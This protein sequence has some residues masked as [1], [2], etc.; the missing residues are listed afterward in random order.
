MSIILDALRKSD[1]ARP[2]SEQQR[3]A[4][5]PLRRRGPPAWLWLL[6]G[7]AT[8]AVMSALLATNLFNEKTISGTAADSSGRIMENDQPVAEIRPLAEIARARS[9][10]STRDDNTAGTAAGIAEGDPPS[11]DIAGTVDN[12]A[13]ISASSRDNKTQDNRPELVAPWLKDMPPEYRIEVPGLTI[14]ALA[15]SDE[16]A[17]RFVLI[18]LRRYSEGERLREGPRV[19]QIQDGAVILEYKN[20]EFA[21]PAR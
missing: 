2:A 17:E 14:N 4:P 7:V 12:P 19:L 13:G 21:L 11:D 9:L 18:N 5:A 1:A 8:V 15:Y 16:P 20:R 3:L 10:T 6:L